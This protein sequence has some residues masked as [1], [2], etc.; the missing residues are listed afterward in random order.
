MAIGEPGD[1]KSTVNT[2]QVRIFKNNSGTWQQIGSG[3]NG[4][5]AYAQYAHSISLSA[6]G[7]RIAIGAPYH[8]GSEGLWSC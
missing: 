1:D 7:S 3:I 8:R 2:G 4:Q 6:D 5:Y